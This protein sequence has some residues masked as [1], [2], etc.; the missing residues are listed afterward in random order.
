MRYLALLALLVPTTAEACGGLFCSRPPPDTAPSPIDQ[1]A[2]RIIFEVLDGGRLS[3]TV[4]IQYTGSASDFA[5]VVPVPSVPDVEEGDVEQFLDLDED[6]RLQVVLPAASPCGS[7]GGGSDSGCGT[8]SARTDGGGDEQ[9]NAPGATSPVTVFAHDFT[10]NFEYHVVGAEETSELIDWLNKNNYN[11]SDNMTPVMDLYNGAA[12][13]FLALKLK[14]GKSAS[15]ITPVKLTYDGNDPMIPIRLTAVAAQPL[16]GILVWIVADQAFAPEN[17]ASA[18]PD[19]EMI[20]FDQNGRTNYYDWVARAAA[21][22]D[23]KLWVREFVGEIEGKTVSRYYTRISPEHMTEDP[24]FTAG[25]AA[26]TQPRIDLTNQPT[27]WGC[28]GVTTPSRCPFNY[29][30]PGS[31]CTMLNNDFACACKEGTVAQQIV[32]P[33]ELNHI[34]CV[35][36]VSEFGITDEAGGAGG[37]F[38][39]CATAGCGEGECVL[40]AGFRTCECAAGAVAALVFDQM[41]CLPP[42]DEAAAAKPAFTGMAYANL[43]GS[44]ARMLIFG[45]FLLAVWRLRRLSVA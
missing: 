29:C 45:L 30:G 37:Q 15:D 42:D 39:P 2:E 34:T 24:I 5:W 27:L 16:M 1:S 23:G 10:G 40:R 6:T 43:G 36:R 26:D 20:A 3:A 38:D 35:P 9:P 7:G 28:S 41:T 4:Q 17:Y 25:N 18:L 14:E 21:E 22:K 44:S 32:G 13:R 11:V 33:D 31:E 19:E 8:S 12:S